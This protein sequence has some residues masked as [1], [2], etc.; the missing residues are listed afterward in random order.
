MMHIWLWVCLP[1]HSAFAN[2]T[3]QIFTGQ[4]ILHNTASDQE[5]YIHS[6]EVRLG[7]ASVAQR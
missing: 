1:I 5:P 6:K 7:A 3:I 4:G 2:P